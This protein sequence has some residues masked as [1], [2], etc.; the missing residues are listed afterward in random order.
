MSQFSKEP[1]FC[2]GDI[3]HHKGHA[4]ASTPVDF[5]YFWLAGDIWN[6]GRNPYGPAFLERARDVFTS[7]NEP[8]Q[9]GNPRHFRLV[10]SALAIAPVELADHI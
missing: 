8:P 10:R 5:G 1:L 2:S 3:R 6:D 9:W 4:A 7:G